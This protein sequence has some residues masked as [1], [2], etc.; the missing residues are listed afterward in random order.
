[1]EITRGDYKIF[2]F[3]RTRKDKTII[4]E[5]PDKMYITF[6]NN[7]TTSKALFQK[8]LANNSIKYSEEDNYYRFEILPEDT[9]NLAYSK[10]Y[11]DIEIINDD[12]P[13]TIYKGFLDV[14]EECTHKANEV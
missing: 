11:F 4:T 6:K 9:N 10:Y 7:T 1:M 5:L 13:R 3:K 12:K 14:T 2:K 8:T